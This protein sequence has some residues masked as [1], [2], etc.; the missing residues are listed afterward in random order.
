LPVGYTVTFDV[1]LSGLE[2]GQEL[3]S[4]A[5]TIDYDGAILGAP[6]IVRGEI[7]PDP[8]AGPSD[9]LFSED[10]GMA[11][12][13]FYTSSGDPAHR[14]TENGVFFSFSTEVL[15]AGSGSFS[16]SYVD[17]TQFPGTDISVTGSALSFQSVIVPEPST[18]VLL[19]TAALVSVACC[20]R[21]RLLSSAFGR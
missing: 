8:L 9:F 16:F 1:R 14:I 12:A 20:L 5:A 15:A 7:V 6:T 11:D 10:D 21:R 4:L 19:A 2:G 13:S 18:C 3:D 17:A